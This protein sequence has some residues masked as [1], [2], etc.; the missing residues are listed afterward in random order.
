MTTDA[1]T[2]LDTS[3][4]ELLPLVETS[5]ATQEEIQAFR[6][7]YDQLGDDFLDTIKSGDPVAIH[8]DG[9]VEIG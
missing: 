4:D 9:T 1:R 7:R 5:L 3:I 2:Q 6:E 8:E